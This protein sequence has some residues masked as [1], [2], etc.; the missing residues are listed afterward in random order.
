MTKELVEYVTFKVEGAGFTRIVRDLVR[1]GRWRH[2]LTTVTDGLH[3]ISMEQAISILD[4][5]HKLIG[6]SHVGMDL[7]EEDKDD[8]DVIEYLKQIEYMYG[9]YWSP[10]GSDTAWKP[11]AYVTDYGIHD[12]HGP[13]NFRGEDVSYRRDIAND[14]F[15]TSTYQIPEWKS[16]SAQYRRA[17][18]YADDPFTDR[19]YM[20]EYEPHTTKKCPVLFRQT[21][22]DLPLWVKP[23]RTAQEAVDSMVAS[24]HL[25]RAR[26]HRETFDEPITPESIEDTLPTLERTDEVVGVKREDKSLECN[27]ID[28]LIPEGM[29]HIAG[30][31]KA[32]ISGDQDWDSKPEPCA[33]DD[34]PTGYV[35]RGG[36]FYGCDYMA[37]KAL[38]T[39]LMK[40]MFDEEPDNP[41]HELDQRGYVRMQRSA[42][43]KDIIVMCEKKPTK[44]QINTVF[45]HS[46]AHSGILQ[47]YEQFMD[48]GGQCRISILG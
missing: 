13:R 19:A 28:D 3:G 48:G 43:D 2:A 1:D 20:L 47:D 5:T 27:I 39:R 46:I 14:G 22:G 31:I 4:G 33:V 9:G 32:Y 21:E 18:T 16:G 38:A 37:H 30:G 34:F 42:M 8:E 12:L 24:G 23:K 7:V 40:H 45:D 29:E 36:K 35:D 10:S 44:R 11:Y 17:M 25:L 26:G 15:A 41:E 6:D